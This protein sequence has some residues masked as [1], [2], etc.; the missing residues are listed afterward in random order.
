MTRSLSLVC[1]MAAGCPTDPDLCAHG[2][3]SLTVGV[4]E[5]DFT[6]TPDGTTVT[7]T[8]GPQGGWHVWT[9]LAITGMTLPPDG[10]VTGHLVATVD[11]EVAAET[12]PYLDPRCDRALEELQAWGIQF[13]FYAATPDELGGKDVD[14]EAS[15]VLA[16]GTTFQGTTTWRIGSA[17]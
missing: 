4:G 3:R 7:P 15:I 13:R 9:A 12:L 2:D 14:V 10:E 11:G 1:L 6:P 8:F 16:D 17:P 5:N